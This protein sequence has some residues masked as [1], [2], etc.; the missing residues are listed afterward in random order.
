ME[1]SR[2]VFHVLDSR[3]EWVERS[4]A[5]RHLGKKGVRD[6]FWSGTRNSMNKQPNEIGHDRD[7]RGSL[8]SMQRAAQRALD[9]ARRIGTA[10]VVCKGCLIQHLALDTPE[11]AMHGDQYIKAFLGRR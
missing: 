10:I 9:V 5:C 7:L 6:N 11:C 3:L 1:R 8:A 4:D 2:D